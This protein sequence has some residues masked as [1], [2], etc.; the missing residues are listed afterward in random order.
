V[1]PVFVLSC[2]LSLLMYIINFSVFVQVCQQLPP[3]GHPIAVNK[4]HIIYT[5]NCSKV[6]RHR[7]FQPRKSRVAYGP[8]V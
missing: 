5:I 8:L 3:G 2:V 7:F 1:F 6:C 4:Y